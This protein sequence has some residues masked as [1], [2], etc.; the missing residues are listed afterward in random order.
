V[1]ADG[2]GRSESTFTAHRPRE[3]E[4]SR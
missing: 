1:A 3:K 4:V 2:V